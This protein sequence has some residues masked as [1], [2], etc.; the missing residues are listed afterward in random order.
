MLL[1]LLHLAS[2]P[3]TS[4]MCE[5]FNIHTPDKAALVIELVLEEMKSPEKVMLVLF[6][7]GNNDIWT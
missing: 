1:V 7:L 5:K 4:T 2:I 3:N 6:G